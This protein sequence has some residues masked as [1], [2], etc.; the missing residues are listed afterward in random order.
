MKYNSP[1]YLLPQRDSGALTNDELKRWKKELLLQFDLK[2]STTININ[3][4]EYDKN[5]VLQAIDNLKYTPEYH[6][7]LYQNKTLLDFIEKGKTDFFFDKTAWVDFEDVEYRNWLAQWFIPMYDYMLANATN[8]PNRR[9]VRALENLLTCGF[10]LP[11][12]WQDEASQSSYRAYTHYVKQAE[13]ILNDKPIVK[14]DKV[15]LNP[16][17]EPFLSEY[18]AEM[19]CILPKN[20]AEIREDY[21][22]FAHNVIAEVFDQAR[23]HDTIEKNTLKL[24]K[25]AAKIDVRIR[26]DNF[27]KELLSDMW[28]NKF[29]GKIDKWGLSGPL[30]LLIFALLFGAIAKIGGCNNDSPKEEKFIEYH[31]PQKTPS[32]IHRLPSTV[33]L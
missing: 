22:A 9:A 19:L 28:Y 13:N 23:D 18:Y 31:A 2:K 26:N 15:T 32:T 7:R 27:S 24:L 20:F 5:D 4:K 25:K 29:L 16:E 33:K 6:W 14:G 8:T 10:V 30:L 17:I 11:Q 3:Q 1:F 12:E 21:G